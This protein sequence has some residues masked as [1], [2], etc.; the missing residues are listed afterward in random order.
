MERLTQEAFK[1]ERLLK[2][3][4]WAIC[5]E[6]DWCPFCRNF[7]KAFDKLEGIPGL[8]VA[9][10]NMDDAESPLWE[11]FE[12]NVVPTIIAFRD[13]FPVWRRD[14]RLGR[15]LSEKDI[16]DLRVALAR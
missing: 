9:R 7:R 14:G 8:N 4:D 15:G 11:E 12:I 10:A 1:G 2:G 6:A 13:Q 5:F 16:E 3:G